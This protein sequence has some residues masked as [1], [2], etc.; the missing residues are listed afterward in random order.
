MTTIQELL[1]LI[2]GF[3]GL[4]F[5]AYALGVLYFARRKEKL[6]QLHLKTLTEQ[7]IQLAR[8]EGL[9]LGKRMRGQ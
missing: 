8:I 9:L 1:P 6:L 4:L 3:G 5:I 2:G 7:N